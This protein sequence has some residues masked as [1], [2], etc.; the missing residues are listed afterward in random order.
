MELITITI[1]SACAGASKL[2]LSVHEFVKRPIEAWDE[3]L[4]DRA[5]DNDVISHPK[6]LA[7][8]RKLYK[9]ALQRYVSELRMISNLRAPFAI[10]LQHLQKEFFPFLSNSSK[11]FQITGQA[12]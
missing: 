11:S 7:I 1:V 10:V 6:K 2:I 5:K 3:L 12:C 4:A 9:G 8:M